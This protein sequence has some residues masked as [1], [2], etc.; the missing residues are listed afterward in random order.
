MSE[1]QIVIYPKE[2]TKLERLNF[3]NLLEAMEYGLRMWGKSHVRKVEIT[4]ILHTWT[5]PSNIR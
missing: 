5:K 2:G 4:L 1:Y 3:S